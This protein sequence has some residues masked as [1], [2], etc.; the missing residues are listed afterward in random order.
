MSAELNQRVKCDLT[1]DL[2]LS[3]IYHITIYIDVYVSKQFA[4]LKLH[5]CSA[6]VRIISILINHE[7]ILF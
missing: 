3:S 6:S 4:K 2:C 1:N 5:P 7:L